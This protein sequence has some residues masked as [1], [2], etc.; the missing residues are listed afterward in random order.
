MQQQRNVNSRVPWLILSNT[1]VTV[2]LIE[3]LVIYYNWFKNE[4]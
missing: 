4:K 3:P 1:T 2:V